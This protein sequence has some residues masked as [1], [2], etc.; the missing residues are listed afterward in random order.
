M[1]LNGQKLKQ[2]CQFFVFAWTLPEG[3]LET[4]N[5]H[6]SICLLSPK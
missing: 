6:G 1:Q 3:Y 2:V 5:C 4:E